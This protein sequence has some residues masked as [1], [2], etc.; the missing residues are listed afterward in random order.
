MVYWGV[1]VVPVSAFYI[2]L[3]LLFYIDVFLSR[4]KHIW[5]AEN[6]STTLTAACY[7]MLSS[8]AGHSVPA[9][10]WKGRLHQ[11]QPRTSL[12]LR[13]VRTNVTKLT[14]TLTRIS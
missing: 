10:L 5:S 1:A 14:H 13:Y 8:V 7:A 4:M 12:E 2:I 11:T 3:C 6:V 9:R